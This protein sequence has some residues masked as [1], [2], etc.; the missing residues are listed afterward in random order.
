MKKKDDASNL[1]LDGYMTEI[2][3]VNIYTN[4][5]DDSASSRMVPLLVSIEGCCLA[6]RTVDDVRVVE[7]VSGDQQLWD[8]SQ[9]KQ[10]TNTSSCVINFFSRSLLVL[11]LTHPSPRCA[12]EEQCLSLDI[13]SEV[14]LHWA[15]FHWT[16]VYICGWTRLNWFVDFWWSHILE[17]LWARAC[18]CW[19]D[20]C[21]CVCVAADY[22]ASFWTRN[23]DRDDQKDEM[24]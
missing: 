8:F 18:V 24:R 14:L 21:V 5:D 6:S 20:A 11:L 10:S 9:R 13:S 3:S 4:N 2:W 16:G 7:T 1:I 17:Q 12:A 22:W 23:I 19:E 15:A